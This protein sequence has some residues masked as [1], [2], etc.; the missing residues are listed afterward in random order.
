LQQAA[1]NK[2][3]EDRTEGQWWIESQAKIDRRFPFGLKPK[4]S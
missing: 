1:A 3:K 2:K 4:L